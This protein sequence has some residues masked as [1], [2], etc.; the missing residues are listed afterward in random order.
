MGKDSEDEEEEK[1]EIKEDNIKEPEINDTKII[2]SE[3]TPV[4]EDLELDVLDMEGMT[5]DS[6]QDNEDEVKTIPQKIEPDEEETD[7]T[8]NGEIEILD[9]E[10]NLIEKQ[11]EHNGGVKV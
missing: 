9:Q 4:E 5:L 3:K 8:L 7:A 10:E 11:Q 6:D 1:F 2:E